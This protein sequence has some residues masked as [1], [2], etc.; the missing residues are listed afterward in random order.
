MTPSRAVLYLYSNKNIAGSLLG[1]GALAA[2]FTGAI[3]DFWPAIVAGAYGIG[4]L[5]TPGGI[6]SAED[7][8]AALDPADLQAG[9]RRY[10]ARVRKNL[11]ADVVPLVDGILQSLDGIF[12]LLAK[13]SGVA[14]QDR[15]TIT[16]TA[17]SYLPETLQRYLALPPA[18]RNLQPIQDGKTA[19]QL[20]VEQL[21]IL[22][23]K[24]KEIARNLIANDG[25]ALV[26]NGA[27]LR[28][29]FATQPFFK[30]V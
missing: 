29:K 26:E 23:G 24:M 12:P 8:A 17:R 15:Y 19:K 2:F 20:L 28:D 5:A 10:V 27:F 21:A 4:A 3:H 11:P 1:L 16:E 13:Q 9:L 6:P 22:D 14:D 7:A 25:R 18:F 30:P